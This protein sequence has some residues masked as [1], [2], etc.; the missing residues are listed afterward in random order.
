MTPQTTLIQV[1]QHA[2]QI[3]LHFVLFTLKLK[4]RNK[5]TLDFVGFLH[6]KASRI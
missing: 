5:H 6:T 4:H 1:T 3:K 2:Q